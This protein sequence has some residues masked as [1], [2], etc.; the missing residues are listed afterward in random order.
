M[1]SDEQNFFLKKKR[2]KLGIGFAYEKLDMK[3]LIIFCLAIA[4]IGCKNKKPSLSGDDPVSVEDLIE[5]FTPLK[6]PYQLS[7]VALTKKE[8][9]SN[10]IS[11]NVML[12]FVS[13][14][15]L[16]SIF[17]NNPKPKIYSLGR[18]EAND[19]TYL[20]IKTLNAGKNQAFLFAF[21]P[22]DRFAGLLELMR[23]DNDKNTKQI[24][25]IDKQFGINRAITRTHPDGTMS[26]GRQVFAFNSEAKQFM[27]VMTDALDD[28]AGEL[29]NPIDT[30]A[31]KNKYSG[32]YLKDKNNIVSIRDGM[33]PDRFTFFIHFEKNKGECVGELKGDAFFKS[34]NTAVYRT[35]GEPCVLQFTFTA[36]SVA[37]KELEGCGSKRDLK[38]LFDGSYPKKKEPRPKTVAKKKSAK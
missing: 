37:L 31:H 12:Q 21:D 11:Y 4:L 2:F 5:S 14:S 29:I 8:S 27:L 13:D 23:V 18:V 6:L 16:R 1:F 35:S 3:R 30:L 34:A 10:L 24:S 25:T 26:D 7:D 22:D 9:D 33:K 32:D 19:D 17:G 15:I 20:L 36:N 28:N 38:C